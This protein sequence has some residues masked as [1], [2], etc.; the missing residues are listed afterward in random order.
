MPMQP[1][2][3][4]GW[5]P[6]G[7]FFHSGTHIVQAPRFWHAVTVS[8]LWEPKTVAYAAGRG[9]STAEVESIV[10]RRAV[11][12]LVDRRRTA[13]QRRRRLQ[14]LKRDDFLYK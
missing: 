8:G 6:E 1:P 11:R 3:P 5:R 10:I 9:C 7:N 2:R 4:S 12:R 13:R 14:R